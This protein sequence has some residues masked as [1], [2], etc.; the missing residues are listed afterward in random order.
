M[1]SGS[2][3]FNRVKE[4]GNCRCASQ[5]QKHQSEVIR[6]N[7]MGSREQNSGETTSSE[8]REHRFHSLAERER[9]ILH[10]CALEKAAG[11]QHE[12]H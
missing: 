6:E 1:P 12:R 5:S 8:I 7:E 11:E 3:R 2:L 4:C 9:G 10:V